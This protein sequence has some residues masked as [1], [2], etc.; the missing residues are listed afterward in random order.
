MSPR[1]TRSRAPRQG[2]AALRVVGWKKISQSG[3]A[4]RPALRFVPRTLGLPSRMRTQSSPH[5]RPA[6][7]TNWRESREEGGAKVYGSS[8]SWLA[9]S[10][11][12]GRECVTCGARFAARRALRS[13]PVA[14]T[15]A[16]LGCEPGH[17]APK[18]SALFRER[19]TLMTRGEERSCPPRGKRESSPPHGRDDLAP[20]PNHTGSG[21]SLASARC[22]PRA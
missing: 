7:P 3:H 15:L 8:T 4:S 5:L 6:R 14:W 19:K 17:L 16:E 13:H 10:V 20:T 1:K 22:M 2:S 11:V 21:P 9:V 18:F 12:S